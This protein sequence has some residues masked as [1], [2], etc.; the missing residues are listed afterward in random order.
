MKR[1][2]DFVM[3]HKHIWLFLYFPL[4]IVFF[5]IVETY[6]PRSGYWVTN[7]QIDAMIPFVPSMVW[8]YCLFYL[9]FAAT[10][11]PLLL[12]DGPAF[13]RWMYYLIMTFT[14][15][16]IFDLIFPNGQNLRPADFI[17]NSVAEK[18]LAFIWSVDT[19][20]NVFPSM[21]VLGCI[22]DAAAAFDSQV[23]KRWQKCLIFILSLICCMS[24]VFVKQHAI[25]DIVGALAF[26]LPVIIIVYSRQIMKN[27]KI[28]EK[29]EDK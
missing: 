20:T 5:L 18:L 12:W 27:I 24:T 14:I 8:G 28:A 3:T 19:P 26:A 25:I 1:I 13:K 2:L 15:A 23:F 21:H 17:P 6:T 29:V 22:G 7:L 11:I 10:G 16:L 9:L 4:Y